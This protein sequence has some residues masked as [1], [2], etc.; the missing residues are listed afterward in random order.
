LARWWQN[1]ADARDAARKARDFVFD[2]AERMGADPAG[3]ALSVIVVASA[4][5]S[6]T[7]RLMPMRRNSGWMSRRCCGALWW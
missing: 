5:I 6:N 2:E 4:A 1:P 3:L 7:I